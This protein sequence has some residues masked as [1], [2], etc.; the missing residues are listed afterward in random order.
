[1]LG[2]MLEKEGDDSA[3]RPGGRVRGRTWSEEVMCA[4]TGY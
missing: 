2:F 4:G 1:M 3:E